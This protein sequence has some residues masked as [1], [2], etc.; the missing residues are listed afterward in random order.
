MSLIIARTLAT[1]TSY[2]CLYTSA[3]RPMAAT[4]TN[5]KNQT[6]SQ[7]ASPQKLA[8]AENRIQTHANLFFQVSHPMKFYTKDVIY[9]DNIRGVKSRGFIN[10][11]MQM[12]L[13]QLYH[14]IR[15][16]S[17]NLEILNLVKYPEE[18]FIKIRWRIISRRGVIAIALNASGVKKLGR[19]LWKD[20]ISTFHVNEEGLIHSHICDNVD[21]G[22]DETDKSTLKNP[23]VNQGLV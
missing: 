10:Y 14:N 16:S 9:I 5:Q 11:Y 23:I 4:Q 7:K 19:E 15:Y 1:R 17:S 18:S 12:K 8:E 20:G 21:R 6:E 13:I 22:L 3:F 2:R